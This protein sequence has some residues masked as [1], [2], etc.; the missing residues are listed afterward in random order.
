MWRDLLNAKRARHY[1]GISVALRATAGDIA[2][3]I[4]GI[5][6]KFSFPLA[7]ALAAALLCPQPAS[8]QQRGNRFQVGEVQLQFAEQQQPNNI[9]PAA[10]QAENTTE[11]TVRRFGIGVQGGAGLSP[12]LI[13]FGAHGRF[14]PIF[15]RDITFRPAVEFGIG[16]VTTMFGVNLDVLYEFP[17][18]T[19]Q[20]RWTPYIGAGPNFTLDHRGF[21]TTLQD[22]TTA[23]TSRFNF[24]DTDFTGGFNFIAGAR[25]QNGVYFELNATAYGVSNVRLLAGFNF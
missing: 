4:G 7:V 9:P 19:R 17:G 21:E 24:S 13:N 8:A 22:N 6:H 25:S 14:G 18:A 1:T 23:T 12:E 3:R 16:E 5:V 11:R 20:T 10:R 15:N 2:R